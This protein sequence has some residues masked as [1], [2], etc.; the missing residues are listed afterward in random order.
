[1]LASATAAPRKLRSVI[2]PKPAV[3]ALM[4]PIV[5]QQRHSGSRRPPTCRCAAKDSMRA[6]SRRTKRCR[7][8]D[9]RVRTAAR[10]AFADGCVDS[11]SFLNFGARRFHSHGHVADDFAALSDRPS[12]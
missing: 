12:A 10:T 6:S 4:I 7:R 9:L 8:C 3:A 5:S 11:L 1:M 2:K